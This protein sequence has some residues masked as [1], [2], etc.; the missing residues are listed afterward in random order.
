MNRPDHYII[1]LLGSAWGQLDDAM[2]IAE[3]EGHS[4]IAWEIRRIH[5][6]IDSLIDVIE[7]KEYGDDDVYN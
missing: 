3:D 4:A 1:P 2:R 6:Q 5:A 7:N